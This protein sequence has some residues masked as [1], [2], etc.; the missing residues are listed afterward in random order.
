MFRDLMKKMLAVIVIAAMLIPMAAFAET[1]ETAEEEWWNI[2]LLGVDTRSASKI[3]GRAD[4]IMVLSVNRE[5][6]EVKIT[7]ILRDCWVKFS[8]GKSNKIN[9]GYVYGGGELAMETVNTYFDMDIQHYAVISMA[10]LVDVVDL[11][12]GIDIE[13]SESERKYANHYVEDYLND[14]EQYDGDT[15]VGENGMVHLNGLQA[16]AYLR[17]RYTDSDFM[18]VMRNQKV[19]IN[20]VKKAQDMDINVLMENVDVFTACIDTNMTDE[21]LMELATL[22]LA[23]DTETI[24]Q[25][26]IPVDGSY[27]SGTFD[28]TWMIRPNYEKNTEALH[29]FIY[30]E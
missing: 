18:R 10:N 20:V 23:A 21:E 30:G 12:G 2:L 28:G 25:F 6:G 17:N 22:G 1:T 7:S 5:T 29:E 8:N 24:E 13:I 11:V 14:I 9:A 27:E 3:E 19:L 26:R 4:T 15:Y 16:V